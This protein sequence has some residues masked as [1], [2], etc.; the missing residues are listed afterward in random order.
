MNANIVGVYEQK[1]VDKVELGGNQA[2]LNFYNKL[3]QGV[4]MGA[5]IELGEIYS[6]LVRENFK[7]VCVEHLFILGNFMKKFGDS[8]EAQVVLDKAKQFQAPKP[9]S[10]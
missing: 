1:K 10:L 8:Q 6:T 7:G 9:S 3:S 2:I 4:Y 5:G